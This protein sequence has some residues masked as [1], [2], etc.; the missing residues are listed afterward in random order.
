[1]C[2]SVI[3]VS[4]GQRRKE[5]VSTVRDGERVTDPVGFKSQH[6]RRVGKEAEKQWSERRACRCGSESF[7]LLAMVTVDGGERLRNGEA[8]SWRS[9]LQT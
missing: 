8:R 7:P 9:H 5:N 6:L 2:K 3:L 4:A 1:M